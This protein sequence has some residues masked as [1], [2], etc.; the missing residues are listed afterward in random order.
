MLVILCDTFIVNLSMLI[1]VQHKG[2]MQFYIETAVKFVWDCSGISVGLLWGSCGFA[3]VLLWHCC[4]MSVV[5]LLDCCEV[6]AVLL[7]QCGGI[8]V[9][10]LGY[11]CGIAVRLMWYCCG[12]AMFW[13]TVVLPWKRCTI[14]L[15]FAGGFL[16]H[17]C[18]IAVG[19]LWYLPFI[20]VGLLCDLCGGIAAVALVLLQY[21]WRI[22]VVMLWGCRWI[23]CGLAGV[24]ECYCCGIAMERL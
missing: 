1:S 17:C 12:T 19:L 4:G 8:A 15:V 13:I 5:F 22:A 11:C 10:L 2:S 7:W 14:A 16:C 21:L 18:E 6:A 20:A 24:L 23:C 3:V 9:E